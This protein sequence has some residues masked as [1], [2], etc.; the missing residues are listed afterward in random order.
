MAIYY[1]QP[2]DEGVLRAGAVG[3]LCSPATGRWVLAATILGTS[4]A[5][6]DGTAVNIALP[7]VQTDLGAS[8]AQL[9]WVVEAYALFLAALLLV[10]GSLG[11]RIGRRRTF[12]W[13]IGIFALASLWC[14]LAPNVGQLVATRA[15]QGLGG[16]FLVPASL[17]IIASSFD[18]QGPSAPG[19]ASPP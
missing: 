5:F 13:G 18:D 19:L 7:A 12:A 15:L 17:A 9:Q 11:D 14:G 16:A 8:I 2:G 4:M 3:A 6:I 10:G 1:K